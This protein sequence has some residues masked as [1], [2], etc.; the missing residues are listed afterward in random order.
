MN[1]FPTKIHDYKNGLDYTL[2]GDYYLPDLGI[3]S[4][5]PIGKYGRARMK[6]LKEHRPGL[7]SRLLLS[8]KL[9]DD[10]HDADAE[11]Q[12]LLDEMIPR[13]ASA[14]GVNEDLKAADPMKWVGMMNAIKAQVEEIIWND[15]ILC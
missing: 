15:V 7:Y 9:Y 6:Y 4:S 14:A 2:V 10:L 8:G 11:A 13:M 5:Q 1:T 12:H 3:E